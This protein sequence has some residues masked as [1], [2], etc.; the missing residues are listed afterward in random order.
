MSDSSRRNMRVILPAYLWDRWSMDDEQSA[1][2][3]RSALYLGY[4][5]ES[6]TRVIALDRSGSEVSE[7]LRVAPLMGMTDDD[8]VVKSRKQ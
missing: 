1:A 8:V 6:V 5:I 3:V 7:M 2:I 4:G